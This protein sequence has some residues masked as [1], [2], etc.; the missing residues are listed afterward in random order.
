MYAACIHCRTSG[1]LKTDWT[2]AGVQERG[3]AERQAVN[4]V[5]QGSAADICKLVMVAV[6]EAAPEVPLLAQL[7]DELLWEV[8]QHADNA[9]HCILKAFRA[10]EH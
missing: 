9:S 3:Q 4:F 10:N 2:C 5:I 8:G 6:A 7:H 1:R